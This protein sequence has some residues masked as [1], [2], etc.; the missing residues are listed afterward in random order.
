GRKSKYIPLS[1]GS[2]APDIWYLQTEWDRQNNCMVYSYYSSGATRGN[3][4]EP[5]ISTISY[6][7]TYTDNTGCSFDANV[8]T[9]ELRYADREDKQTTYAYGAASI[10][11]VRLA[12]ISTI[13]GSM[14]VRRYELTYHV[15]S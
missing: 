9:V 3:D 13:V 11:T 12:T 4:Y 5:I 2:G 15:S 1:M 10:S 14:Y 8:R 7:G 6:T